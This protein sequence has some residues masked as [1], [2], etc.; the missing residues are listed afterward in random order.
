MSALWN[1]YGR[2]ALAMALWCNLAPPVTAKEPSTSVVFDVATL[3]ECQEVSSPEFRELHPRE[4]LVEAHLQISTLI[5]GDPKELTE[6][7][8][9][10]DSAEHTFRIADYLPRTTLSSDYAGNVGVEEK[11]EQA[12]NLGFNVAG[13]YGPVSNSNATVSTG[14][15]AAN[16]KRY[17]LLPP[18]E[19][20]LASGTVDRENGVYFKLRPSSRTSV[21]GAQEFV[22]ILRV[23]ANWRADY[24]IVDCQAVGETSRPGPFGSSARTIKGQGK[25]LVGLF[26]RGDEAAYGAAAALVQ[27]EARL[28][29]VAA[30]QR[31]RIEK[32]AAPTPVHELAVQLAVA[33][34]R[35][36][37]TWLDQILTGRER[38]SVKFLGYLPPA[39]RESAMDYYAVRR[40]LRA[41]T[42]G[43]VRLPR[44]ESTTAS[45]G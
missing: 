24:L 7:F 25:F 29:S 12:S 45:R 21:E 23:P 35:I 36:P 27:A 31:E 39:V 40:Q 14:D 2:A 15:K 1:G 22:I 16:C 6:L 18:L 4:K 8:Y 38:E 9:R 37:R 32:G 19:T 33:A 3:I 30:S 43:G 41:V 11:D 13:A 44:V 42:A 28:R 26:V 20:V 5:Q 34:P 17:E 10:V